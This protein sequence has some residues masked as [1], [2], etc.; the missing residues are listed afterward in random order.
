MSTLF[1]VINLPPRCMFWHTDEDLFGVEEALANGKR[2]LDKTIQAVQDG[3]LSRE[4]LQLY[5]DS[6]AEL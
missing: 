3:K 5:K 1:N 6:L 2:Y 4:D